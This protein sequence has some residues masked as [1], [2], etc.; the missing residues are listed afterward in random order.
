V[1]RPEVLI[2][3]A[4]CRRGARRHDPKFKKR[5]QAPLESERE[6]LERLANWPRSQQD[7]LS[8]NTHYTD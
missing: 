8:Q 4:P 7:R 6:V 1:W 3:R 2:R 5:I